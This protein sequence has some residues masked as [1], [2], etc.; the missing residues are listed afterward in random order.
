LTDFV[1]RHVSTNKIV[2]CVTFNKKKI[3][4]LKI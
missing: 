1:K 2:T 4:I 3:N